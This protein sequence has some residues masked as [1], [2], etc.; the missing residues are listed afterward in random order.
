M[1]AIRIYNGNLRGTIVAF[2]PG[3]VITP[4][5]LAVVVWDTGE[6]ETREVRGLRAFNQMARLSTAIL[7]GNAE[8]EIPL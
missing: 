8:P 4:T 3:D 5:A 1:T 6:L 2:V 7:A